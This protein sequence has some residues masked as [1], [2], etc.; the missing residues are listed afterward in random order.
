[1]KLFF[2]ELVNLSLFIAAIEE[3]LL[4][5]VNLETLAIHL[6]EVGRNVWMDDKPVCLKTCRVELWN[7]AVQGPP[8]QLDVAVQP[9][10][11]A[12]PP[13]YLVRCCICK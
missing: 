7:R 13:I 9:E 1:M 3:Q 2:L 5:S 10:Q 6:R 11:M 12:I 4:R 8:L